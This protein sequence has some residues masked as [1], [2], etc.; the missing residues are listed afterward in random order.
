M[1]VVTAGENF[2]ASSVENQSNF[3]K[4]KEHKRS[5]TIFG[6]LSPMSAIL[7]S[8][9]DT[10]DTS[11][12]CSWHFQPFERRFS[13]REDHRGSITMPC[14]LQ[15]NLLHICER[16]VDHG[17]SSMVPS[18]KHLG[19]PL[20]HCTPVY[21]YTGVP[22]DDTSSKRHLRCIGKNS[23]HWLGCFGN[24]IGMSCFQFW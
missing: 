7:T 16:H 21:L 5:A 14:A 17:F 6:S 24:W 23:H 2:F 12:I 18:T 8:K 13:K 3:S 11:C 22:G 20:H 19:L 1:T 15:K 10:N 4:L 9:G